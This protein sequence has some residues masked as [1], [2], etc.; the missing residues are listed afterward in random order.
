MKNFKIAILKIV[1]PPV[2]VKAFLFIVSGLSLA[3]TVISGRSFIAIPFLS[4]IIT[5]YTLAVII[6]G[7]PTAVTK[8]K[9]VLYNNPYSQVLITDIKLRTRLRLTFGLFF[10]FFYAI[11]KFFAGLFFRSEWLISIGVYY[12][13][14]CTS[15]FMLLKSADETHDDSINQRRREL[16]YCRFVGILLFVLSSVISGMAAK[17]IYD[18]ETV[19]YPEYFFG[20]ITVYTACRLIS[21]VYSLIKYRHHDKPFYYTTKSLDFAS[22]LMSLLT[23]QT[24]IL[25]RYGTN[26]TLTRSLN[27][28]TSA[29]VL[30][31]VI[32]IS[33]NIIVKNT[34]KI[35]KLVKE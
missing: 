3:F 15:K 27:A 7:L 21:A 17:M 16:K 5:A 10:N 13:L 26:P 4:F 18:N 20:L 25:A 31:T 28:L 22:A 14:I 24:A 1:K 12:F 34:R 2:Y 30:L 19:G 32:I 33:I 8:G 23:L 9:T 6:A 11:F 29:V 35:K